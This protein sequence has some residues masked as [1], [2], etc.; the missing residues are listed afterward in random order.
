MSEPPPKPPGRKHYYWQC[1]KCD[2][3]VV[4]KTA[5]EKCIACGAEQKDFVLLEHD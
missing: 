1:Q 4:S 2:H 3:I 5:P